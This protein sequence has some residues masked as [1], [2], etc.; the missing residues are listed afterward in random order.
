MIPYSMYIKGERSTEKAKTLEEVKG[1]MDISKYPAL[2]QIPPNEAFVGLEYSYDL[3]IFD[4]DTE[5]KDIQVELVSAPKWVDLLGRRIYGTP[6][7]NDIGT[8]KV[9]LK[10]SDGKNSIESSYYIVV[11][12][13]GD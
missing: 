12:P 10:I 4:A 3:K 6:I 5:N 11:L 2:I 9:V 1:S 7:E 13:N 8:G